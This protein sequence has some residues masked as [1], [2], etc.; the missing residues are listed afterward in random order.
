M[1]NIYHR[2]CIYR[3]VCHDLSYYISCTTQTLENRLINHK[4]LAKSGV[5][6]VYEYINTIGWDDVII[7]CIEEYPCQTKKELLAREKHYLHQAKNDKLCLNFIKTNI[8]KNGKIYR[9]QCKDGYYYFGSTTQLLSNRLTHHKHLSKKDNTIA[10]QHIKKLGWENVEIQLVEDYPCEIKKELNE[11]EDYYIQQSLKDLLCLNEN[12]AYVSAEE[13]KINIQTYYQTHQ[14]EIKQRTKQYATDHHE[15]VLQK[16]AAYREKNRKLLNEKQKEYAKKHQEKIKK[17]LKEYYQSH[18]EASANY[19]KE[20]REK[21]KE[22]VR[23]YKRVW[24]KKN[25]DENADQIQLEREEKKKKRQNKT[26]E[27]IT[28]YNEIHTCECGGTYQSYRKQRHDTNKKHINYMVSLS[29]TL[30]NQTP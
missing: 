25:T 13:K 7:E 20:Y 21:N 26:A 4:Q 22:K 23:E 12:R 29:G 14:E 9:L 6:K 27:R 28:K 18:K 11:R 30:E 17:S 3:M 2:S 15:D 19:H 10:Y 1:E 5:N 16:H 8:Y 24:A